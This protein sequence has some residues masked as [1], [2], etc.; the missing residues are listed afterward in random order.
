MIKTWLDKYPN[1]PGL[2]TNDSFYFLNNLEDQNI[3][4]SSYQLHYDQICFIV[5]WKMG[6]ILSHINKGILIAHD[7][8]MSSKLCKMYCS[9]YP[10][11]CR[12]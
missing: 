5:K 1:V 3:Y 11:M 6:P 7:N 4:I 8:K 2:I 10:K 9:S 12:I